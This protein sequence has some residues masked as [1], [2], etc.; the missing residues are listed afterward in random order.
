MC[1]T[2]ERYLRGV[3]SCVFFVA[4][5]D[6][7]NDAS[8]VWKRTHS[9]TDEGER[10]WLWHVWSCAKDREHRYPNL[11][12]YVE[13]PLGSAGLIDA[14]GEDRVLLGS[15][16][17]GGKFEANVVRYALLSYRINCAAGILCPLHGRS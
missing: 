11:I 12:V 13:R 16:G 6:P 7:R 9:G 15:S 14:R 5:S 17:G 2:F 1:R 8:E 4:Q 3:S 10:S